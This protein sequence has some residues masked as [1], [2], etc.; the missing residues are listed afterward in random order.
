[1]LNT[2]GT[3]YSN[4]CGPIIILQSLSNDKYLI[5]F[6]NTG[7]EKVVRESSVKSGSIRDPYALLNCGVACTGDVKTKG[8]N[9]PYYNVW[10]SMIHR[11]YAE[12]DGKYANYKNA[13]VCDRWLT[14]ENFLNDCKLIDGFDEEL[15]LSGNLVL[16][17]DIKQR[18]QKNKVYSLDTCT[19]VSKRENS[20]YQDMQMKL[21][22]AISPTGETYISNNMTE[23]ARQHNLTRRHISGVLHNRAKTTQGWRFRFCEEIV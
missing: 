17:K 7:T 6:L 14:F 21:F 16:D 2:N 20:M 22:E 3:Y 18:Y 10:N 5:K 23:F 8:K 9:H 15:F 1:M 12:Q 11:C 13:T 4:K 19:W